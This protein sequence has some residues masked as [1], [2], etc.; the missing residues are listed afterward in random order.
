VQQ[1]LLREGLKSVEMLSMLSAEDLVP[2]GL[3][4]LEAVALV[5][6][7]QRGRAATRTSEAR[8]NTNAGFLD[9]FSGGGVCVVSLF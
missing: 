2:C 5:R 8:M 3:Q 9:S 1:Q 7:A 4:P 6:A